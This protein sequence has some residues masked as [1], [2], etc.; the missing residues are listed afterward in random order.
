[1]ADKKL[2]VSL[3]LSAV[4]NMT[5][6]I[7][8]SVNRSTRSLQD[9][10]KRADNISRHAMR[11]GTQ[12]VA[13]GTA[14]TGSFFAIAQQTARYGDDVAK[15]ADRLGVSV[16]A[17]QEYRH[18]AQLS[19]MATQQFDSALQTF[20]KNAGMAAAGLG[21][22]RPAF[23][24]LGITMTD[25]AGRMKP[26]E[27]LL[28]EVADRMA[29]IEDPTVRGQIAMMVFGD[30]G[31]RMVNMLSRGSAGLE[32]M[33]QEA[34]ALG[35]VMSDENARKSEQFSDDLLRL[36]TR[37][38][39]VRNEIGIALMPMFNE[40]IVTIGEVSSKVIEWV[41]ANPEL[42]Q[43]MG[44]IA[45][46]AGPIIAGVG[47]VGITVGIVAKGLSGLASGALLAVKAFGFLATVTKVL[48]AVMIANP[49]GAI[50]AGI[51]VAAL[52]IYRYWEPISQFFVGIW[53][54][55][56][57][58]F[59]IG[60]VRGVIEVFKTFTPMVWIAKGMNKLIDYLFGI[61]LADAGMNII[62]SLWDGMKSKAGEMV[63]WFR[64]NVAQRI[65]DFLPFSPA[66][67]GPL[68][69]IHR[70]RLVETI[71]ESMKPGPVV[72]A[73]RRVAT[74]AAVSLPLLVNPV[75]SA[76]MSPVQGFTD[77]NGTR[78]EISRVSEPNVNASSGISI[79]YSPTI[80]ISG[81]VNDSVQE[82]FQAQLRKH[83]DE[84][85]RI[86]KQETERRRVTSF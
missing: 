10:Q 65:R 35:I 59:D 3:V 48:T 17:L 79:V 74:A 26:M 46:I 73:M 14:I 70:I 31:S 85:I 8:E 30:S 75:A 51:A 61:N 25:N 44:K 45:A 22:A 55:I 49:I 78:T 69:D 38:G 1:M 9:F 47:A 82:E 20:Q 53:N 80:N 84:I 63:E 32:E 33:R 57:E 18:A 72:N 81:S 34:R 58:A 56:K 68:R 62:N 50:V 11:F 16:E 7:Q 29:G 36:T 2:K 71:S 13:M 27:S 39:A 42:I 5:R 15:T 23:E 6:K 60:F 86:I 77:T 43:Q 37:L 28:D 67:V 66:K 54:N 4:D 40:M 19:G 83:K 52:L 12:A 64:V 24:A 21:R 41:Q 76:A